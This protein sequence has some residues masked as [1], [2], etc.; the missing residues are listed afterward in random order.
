[1]YSLLF[2]QSTQI[3]SIYNNNGSIS[4][5][6]RLTHHLTLTAKPS[7]SIFLVLSSPAWSFPKILASF[8]PGK[9]HHLLKTELLF[10]IAD[11]VL[12]VSNDLK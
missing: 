3:H 4:K 1:M 9:K 12:I 8:E 5:L 7:S 2:Q 11:K 10:T 6:I